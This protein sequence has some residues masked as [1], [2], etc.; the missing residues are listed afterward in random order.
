MTPGAW[1]VR[2]SAEWSCRAMAGLRLKAPEAHEAWP[3]WQDRDSM[4][5]SENPGT[6]TP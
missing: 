3:C 4:V 1:K 6:V 2:L 5:T